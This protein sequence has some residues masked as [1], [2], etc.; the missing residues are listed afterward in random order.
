MLK[1]A[2]APNPKAMYFTALGLAYNQLGDYALAVAA[3]SRSLQLEPG[4]AYAML[5]IGVAYVGMGDDA[6]AAKALRQ[7][8]ILSIANNDHRNAARA[9]AAFKAMDLQA[10]VSVDELDA[11]EAKIGKLLAS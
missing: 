3:L 4:K 10:Q 8:M 6:E 11:L 2:G 9:L 7:S 5:Q 1:A